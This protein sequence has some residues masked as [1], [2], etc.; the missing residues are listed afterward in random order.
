MQAA[1]S[2]QG[3]WQR[4]GGKEEV[5]KKRWQS[6]GGKEEVAKKRGQLK[7]GT[8][9]RLILCQ[10]EAICMSSPFY[11]AAAAPLSWH[12]KTWVGGY[13]LY[14]AAVL[15]HAADKACCSAGGP[16]RAGRLVAVPTSG[17]MERCYWGWA[18]RSLHSSLQQE[19]RAEWPLPRVMMDCAGAGRWCW[20]WRRVLVLGAG[21]GAGCWCWVLVLVQTWPQP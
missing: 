14:H 16:T 18:S 12:S 5:A 7:P 4:S 8:T 13:Q 10:L 15:W 2:R 3:R 6:R 21:A 20:C 9:C 17:C 19:A 1:H 11:G